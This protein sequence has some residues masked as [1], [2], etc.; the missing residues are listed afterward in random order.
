[1]SEF[2]K[3]VDRL[4]KLDLNQFFE[5]EHKKTNIQKFI[6]DSNRN[7]L[8]VK[9]TDVEGK[10][11]RT[12]AAT[13]GNVYSNA[14]I[15]IKRSKGQP[16]NRVTLYDT[17]KWQ[18][19]F[20]MKINKTF[21]EIQSNKSRLADIEKNVDMTNVLGL[22]QD[23]NITLSNMLAHSVAVNLVKKVFDV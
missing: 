22:T 23:Q 19:S 6:L 11:I 3:Y 12:Y 18:G 14:T 10:E 9:G 17:G 2:K 4:K 13:A 7:R 1:M 15:D 21:A 20:A 16:T 5:I 8:R